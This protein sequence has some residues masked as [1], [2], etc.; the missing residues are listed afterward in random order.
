MF[1][2]EVFIEEFNKR[3]L[4]S[5]S[6]LINLIEEFNKDVKELQCTQDVKE[7]PCTQDFKLV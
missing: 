1:V 6:L 5:Y 3:G 2:R 4:Y 7:L